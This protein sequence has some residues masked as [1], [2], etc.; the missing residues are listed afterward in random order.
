MSSVSHA[1]R[2]D[3]EAY[4]RSARLDFSTL[5]DELNELLGPKLVAYIAGVQEARTVRQWIVAECDVRAPVP[6]R[7]RLAF[8]VAS[9]I[10]QHDS[11]SVARAWFQGLNPQLDDRSA[12]RLLREGDLDEVGPQILSAARAFVSGG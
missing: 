10:A 6:D 9:L 11:A 12:A 1:P 7:L 8:Q 5:V 4:E 3:L 2:P